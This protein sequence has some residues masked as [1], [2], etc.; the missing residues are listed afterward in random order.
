VSLLQFHMLAYECLKLHQDFLSSSFSLAT[1]PFIGTRVP[2][3][4]KQP[5]KAYLQGNQRSIR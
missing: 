3:H 2:V 1:S 5:F 4:S